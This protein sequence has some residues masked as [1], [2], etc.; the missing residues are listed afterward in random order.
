MKKM[1]CLRNLLPTTKTKFYF[2]SLIETKMDSIIVIEAFLGYHNEI[3]LLESETPS[4][5]TFDAYDE[6]KQESIRVKT[7]KELNAIFEDYIDWIIDTNNGK[8]IHRLIIRKSF[9][10]LLDIHSSNLYYIEHVL[11]EGNVIRGRGTVWKEYERL[12]KEKVS[13]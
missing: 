1:F 4:N 12:F 5:H 10:M 8:P 9:E 11:D 6:K 3:L 7:R 13:K 2:L